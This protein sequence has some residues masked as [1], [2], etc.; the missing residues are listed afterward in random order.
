[1]KTKELLDI[2]EIFCP[3]KSRKVLKNMRVINAVLETKNQ[4]L[5]RKTILHNTINYSLKDERAKR[6]Y[7]YLLSPEERKIRKNLTLKFK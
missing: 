4:E 5:I 7:E 2:A 3:P 1:M 6:T